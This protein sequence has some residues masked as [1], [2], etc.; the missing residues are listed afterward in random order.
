[1]IPFRVGHGYDVHRLT[2]GRPL[3]LGGIT[4]PCGRGLAGHSDADVLIHA[5]IVA[6]LGAC[7]LPDIGTC[8]PDSDDAYLNID[9]CILLKKT[10]DMIRQ[11]QFEIGNMDITVIAQQPKLAPHIRLMQQKM[12]QVCAVPDEAVHIKA[13]TE[14]GLGFTGRGEGIAAH[15]VVLVADSSV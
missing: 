1:M 11:K 7:G 13:T 9:S 12:A 3:V 6:L 15:C 5:V 10:C 8:F 2:E 14:E 4:I